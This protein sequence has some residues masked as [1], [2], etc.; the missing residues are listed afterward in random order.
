M[1]ASA[2]R[3]NLSPMTAIGDILGEVV[4][5]LVRLVLR[6]GALLLRSAAL[7]VGAFVLLGLADGLTGTG[8][9]AWAP[10][11]VAGLLTIPVVTLA[12][13]RER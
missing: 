2:L 6:P 1:P 5:T 13:R 7:A 11:V 8:W 10:L 4:P 9:A 3:A 12:A